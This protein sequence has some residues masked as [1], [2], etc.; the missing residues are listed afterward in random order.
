MREWKQGNKEN[1]E[2]NGQ[3]SIL[4]RRAILGGKGKT[5]RRKTLGVVRTAN[6]FG[7]LSSK[8]SLPKVNDEI[9][10][11]KKQRG[12]QTDGAI[13]LVGEPVPIVPTLK[14]QDSNAKTKI[15]SLK[16][17]KKLI[18]R[19]VPKKIV[20]KTPNVAK[21]YVKQVCQHRNLASGTVFDKCVHVHRSEV[22]ICIDTSQIITLHSLSSLLVLHYE[23]DS[24]LLL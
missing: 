3:T 4:C 12:R 17:A 14:S 13:N 24:K 2:P 22:S 9:P 5:V 21:N 20:P 15:S 1:F 18:K 11:N 6:L 8:N 16:Q 10:L 19:K 23:L 7:K